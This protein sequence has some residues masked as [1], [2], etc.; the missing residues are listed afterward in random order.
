MPKKPASIVL[1]SLVYAVSPLF[2]LAQAAAIAGL[3]LLGPGSILSR[4]TPMDAL[5]LLA[6]PIAAVSI[7][8]VRR[9]GWY[10]FMLA[11]AA[12]AANNL[13]VALSSPNRLGL[14]LALAYDIVLLCA[15][16]FFLRAAII[17]PYFVPRLRWWETERRYGALCYALVGRGPSRFS[18]T[19]VN[20]SETGCFARTDKRLV[21][22]KEI[23]LELRCFGDGIHLQATATRKSDIHGSSGYALS[24]RRPG[25]EAGQALHAM[26]ARLAK[27]GLADRKRAEHGSGEQGEAQSARYAVENCAAISI[28]GRESGAS[29]LDLSRKGCLLLSGA[30][31]KPGEKHLIGLDCLERPI[32]LEG[33]VKWRIDCGKAA[34]LGVA[35]SFRNRREAW[36]ISSLVRSLKGLGAN[37]RG[38]GK[39]A[40]SQEAIRKSALDSPYRLLRK[41]LPRNKR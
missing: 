26:A 39:P 41:L 16:A 27:A 17:A 19:I 8:S 14:P 18:V 4:L 22:G 7:F 29:I 2:I 1:L 38:R 6:Y 37:E 32:A 34:L 3:P 25:A 40:L 36:T 21:L 24:F 9:W 11:T 20:V 30:A 12:L 13:R 15:A 28:E 23:P 31:A 33:R 10:A 35:F 5:V